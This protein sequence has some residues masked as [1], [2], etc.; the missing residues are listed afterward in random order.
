MKI[1]IGSDHAGFTLKQSLVTWLKGKGFEVEDEGASDFD[2]GDDFPKFISK[3]AREVRSD[4]DNSRGIAI[5]GSGNGEAM[6][7][8]RFKGVRASVYYGGDRNIIKMS[9]KHN[10]ANVLC[11]GARFISEDE[12]KEVIDMWLHEPFSSDPKYERR[13]KELDELV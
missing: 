3:V 9:R 4:L 13:N 8:N 10:N 5:G 1:F 12:A 6:M 7:A 2:E 11:L